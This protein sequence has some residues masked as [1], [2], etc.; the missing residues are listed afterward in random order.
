M[1]DRLFVTKHKIKHFKGVKVESME[2]EYEL[3]K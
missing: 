1:I 3:K 2:A